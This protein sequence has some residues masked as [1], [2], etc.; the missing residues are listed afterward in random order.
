MFDFL[1]FTFKKN[2]IF[3]DYI[4]LDRSK[5]VFWLRF[6]DLFTLLLLAFC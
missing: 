4:L 2:H 6:V 1:K 5:V 3:Y